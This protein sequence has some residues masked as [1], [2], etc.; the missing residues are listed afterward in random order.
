MRAELSTLDIKALAEEMQFL[1]G[2]RIDRIYNSSGLDIIF[3]LHSKEGKQF[4][5]ISKKFFYICAEK[6]EIPQTPSEFCKTLRRH[7]EKR[8]IKEIKQ[9]E[10]E[11]IVVISTENN[12]LIVELFGQANI[13]L[14][15]KDKMIITSA[16]VQATGNI[17]KPKAKYEFPKKGAN[18]FKL[19]E[20]EFAEII[21]NS[22]SETVKAVASLVGGVY[23]EEICLRAGMDK[24][25]K[26]PNESEVKRLFSA[27][28]SLLREQA[29]PAVV[30]E[31]SKIKDA[32]PFELKIYENFT[33]VAFSNF[34]EA[35]DFALR[36]S[37]GQAK[38]TEAVKKYSRQMEKIHEIISSQKKQ[39]EILKKEHGENK[40]AGELIYENYGEL[41][42][43]IS[44]FEDAKKKMS[45]PEIKSKIR[46]KKIVSIENSKIVVDL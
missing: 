30:Y 27:F 16:R 34:Y 15:G 6:K 24:N 18:A 32:V 38:E 22:K 33:K 28:G 1:A 11:R 13:I 39:L 9:H 31:N 20:K 45:L 46:N 21:K 37:E 7:L 19:K 5:V 26:S 3:Q 41:R 4:L 25:K 29:A 8:R 36:E 44:Q 35:L 14:C 2:A 23:A 40:R 10:S 17:V 43:L 12:D 42:N